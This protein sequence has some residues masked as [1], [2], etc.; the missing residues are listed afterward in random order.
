MHKDDRSYGIGHNVQHVRKVEAPAA[1]VKVYDGELD[2][3]QLRQQEF[4]AVRNHI[5]LPDNVSLKDVQSAAPI[6][7]GTWERRAP[8]RWQTWMKEYASL[9]NG[10]ITGC[11]GN[12]AFPS[13]QCNIAAQQDGHSSTFVH[14]K[15]AQRWIS[16]RFL[17][18]S[19]AGEMKLFGE[20][21]RDKRDAVTGLSCMLVNSDLPDEEGEEPG[22]FHFLAWG[23]WV[24]L[25][26]WLTVYFS[27]QLPHGGTAP[28]AAPGQTAQDWAC[29]SVLIGYPPRM[30]M[31]GDIRHSLA[32]LPHSDEPLY[33]TPEMTG[34]KYVRKRS[35]AYPI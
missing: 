21:H 14:V 3:H 34:I 18:G 26:L 12:Y 23:F 10:P 35:S 17:D 28:L 19:L 29:R 9:I 20:A 8:R 27:G 13:W 7:F 25:D 11:E 31:E 22:R 16:L 5:L 33:I 1:S 24:R 6:V 32:A 30:I 2:E 4:L 15:V